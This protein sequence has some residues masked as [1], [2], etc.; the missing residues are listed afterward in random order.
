[1]IR[2]FQDNLIS[3]IQQLISN[4]FDAKLATSLFTR[5]ENKDERECNIPNKVIRDKSNAETK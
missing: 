3:K 5:H 1:M 4:T 2:S